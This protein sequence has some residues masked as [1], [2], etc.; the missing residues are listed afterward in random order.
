MLPSATNWMKGRKTHMLNA[1]V[2]VI[3]LA[4]VLNGW[5][6]VQINAF[7]I[8]IAS[9]MSAHRA[10]VGKNGVGQVGHV[11]IACVIGLFLLVGCAALGKID[12]LTGTTPAEEIVAALSTSSSLFGPV[13]GTAVPLAAA[14]IFAILIALGKAKETSEQDNLRK[15]PTTSTPAPPPAPTSRV[16]R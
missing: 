6:D 9:A 15:D 2:I 11:V 13:I 10:G 16:V 7:A 5:G 3:A 4:A 12:P 8:A 1:T 14:S